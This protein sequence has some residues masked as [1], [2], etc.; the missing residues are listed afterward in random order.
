M[1]ILFFFSTLLISTVT[2]AQVEASIVNITPNSEDN[3]LYRGYKNLVE[4]NA[5]KKEGSSYYLLGT[6]CH[7]TNMGSPGNKLPENQYII[8]P[9]KGNSANISLVHNVNGKTTVV[10]KYEYTF[11]NLPVPKIHID[12]QPSGSA[13]KRDAVLI[14]VKYSENAGLDFKFEVSDWTMLINGE[15]YTGNNYM[16]TEQVKA[17]LKEVPS[18][19]NIDITLTVKGEDKVAR[20]IGAQFTV[21]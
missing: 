13:I 15:I 20:K 3:I 8:K 17:A 10:T 14:E 11:A 2:T 16:I 9:G 19:T 4:I 21:E 6:N 18:G 5:E 1:K 7:I 12:N